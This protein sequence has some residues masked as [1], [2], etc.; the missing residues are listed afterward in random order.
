[1]SKTGLKR[2]TTDKF[3]TNQNIIDI[4]F[5]KFKDYTAAKNTDVIIEP[6]AGNGAFIQNIKDT[7]EK[8]YFYDIE[9]SHTDIM[10]ANFL[11]LDL[12][13]VVSK[14]DNVHFIGN[15]PFGRQSSLAKKFIK[16]ICPYAKS[17]SFIL[18]KSFKK[19]SMSK[20]FDNYFHKVYELDLPVNSFNIDNKCVDVPCVFQ[21]W[22]KKD[23]KRAAPQILTPCGYSFVKKNNKPTISF[24][25]VGVNAGNV[26]YDIENKSEQSHY[27]I[28]IENMSDNLLHKLQKI[29]FT[30]DNTVGPRSISKQELIKEFNK[31]IN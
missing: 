7:T 20:S 17:V 12:D 13:S 6:S 24:R 11:E 4:V 21:I 28:K 23:S 14:Q 31:V 29:Q 18:P 16:K 2:D 25:R 1:M 30:F 8:H 26:S 22:I 10:K 15:P 19:E 9:P 3:Y 27:F 5:P